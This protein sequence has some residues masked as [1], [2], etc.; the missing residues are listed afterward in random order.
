MG[1]ALRQGCCSGGHWGRLCGICSVCRLRRGHPALELLGRLPRWGPGHIP[2]A[3]TRAAHPGAGRPDDA[4]LRGAGSGL[5]GDLSRLRRFGKPAFGV[6]FSF[7]GDPSLAA[8]G[9]SHR[10]GEAPSGKEPPQPGEP[11]G[12]AAGPFCIRCLFRCGKMCGCILLFAGFTAIL[13][14]S[15]A[16]QALSRLLAFSGLVS[17]KE[18]GVLLSFLLEV[19]GGTGEAPAKGARPCFTPLVWPLAGCAYTCSFFPFSQNSPFLRGNSS[20]SAFFTVFWRRASF[21]CWRG[22]SPLLLGWCGPL[23]RRNWPWG[24]PPL[25]RRGALSVPYVPGIPRR[26]AAGGER[27]QRVA[28]CAG[29][30]LVL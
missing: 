13:Q 4:L 29:N 16:F 6:A 30:G 15:G 1:Y 17:Q 28:R 7:R 18:A 24:G 3:G 8:A 5:C 10:A 25:R 21:C 19:T 11:G 12:P 27:F 2:P 9:T 14:G 20:Y 23:R 22:C 26:P